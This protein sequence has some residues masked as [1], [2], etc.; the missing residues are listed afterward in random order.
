MDELRSES[1]PYTLLLTMIEGYKTQI[2]SRYTNSFCL[3]NEVHITSIFPPDVLYK[4]MYLFKSDTYDQLKR[5]I[6]LIVYHYKENDKFLTKEM[7]MEEYR[8]FSYL[9]SDYD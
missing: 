1:L 6:N 9:N 3:W 2:H 7:T 5:R 8:E 4:Q